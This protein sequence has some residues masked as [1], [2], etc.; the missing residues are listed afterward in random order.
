MAGFA[1]LCGADVDGAELA[2]VLGVG[3][4]F[5]GDLL[6]LVEG[7]EAFA[8]DGRK[9]DENIA[10][11]VVVGNEAKSLVLIKPFYSTVVH[12]VPPEIS[13]ILKQSKKP[14]P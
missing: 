9:V 10:A 1:A 12:V 11:A 6:S 8:L 3:L 5:E 7:A 13:V 2:A 4:G 14:R